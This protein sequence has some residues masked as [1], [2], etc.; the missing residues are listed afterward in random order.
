MQTINSIDCMLSGSRGTLQSSLVGQKVLTLGRKVSRNSNS[1]P[2][3]LSTAFCDGNL[4]LTLKGAPDTH[5]LWPR[6]SQD[7]RHFALACTQS[8]C[9]PFL[10]LGCPQIGAFAS[11]R[12]SPENGVAAEGLKGRLT[13]PKGTVGIILCV[14]VRSPAFLHLKKSTITKKKKPTTSVFL[15]FSAP[16]VLLLICL[17]FP[18]FRLSFY[19]FEGMEKNGH[20]IP[21][22]TIDRAASA[23]GHGE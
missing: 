8:A 12:G 5:H 22:L 15:L 13:T 1:T 23:L 18:L 2:G 14:W 7:R 20:M 10:S 6:R 21:L 4:F 3:T 16:F 9:C 17:H 19:F 11:R